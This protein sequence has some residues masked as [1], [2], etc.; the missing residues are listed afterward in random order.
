MTMPED[1][2]G[3]YVQAAVFCRMILTEDTNVLSVIRIIDTITI[4]SAPP[5]EPDSPRRGVRTNLM[6]MFRAGSF[7]G[8]ADFE[9]I[10]RHPDGSEEPFGTQSYRFEG[11]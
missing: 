5:A 3:P 7:V 6:V 9:L 11:E 1:R 2:G 4:P 8:D 10:A